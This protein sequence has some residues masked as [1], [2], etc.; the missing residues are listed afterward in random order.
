[1]GNSFF[2]TF[3]IQLHTCWHQLISWKLG[4]NSSER[5][6]ELQRRL[7]SCT[8]LEP[9]QHRQARRAGEE[10]GRRNKDNQLQ[11]A[12]CTGMQPAS[13]VAFHSGRGWGG[14]PC[15]VAP[16]PSPLLWWLGGL[17]MPAI[18]QKPLKP[19]GGPLLE[20]LSSA[21]TKGQPWS[22]SPYLLACLPA[23]LT[24]GPVPRPRLLCPG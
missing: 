3:R 7:K 2:G 14:E 17:S 19:P 10:V 1:M 9:T 20:G 23:C 12:R 13:P 24:G 6:P 21:P 4:T 5:T 8:Y 18:Q 11:T 22:A 15:T 16:S